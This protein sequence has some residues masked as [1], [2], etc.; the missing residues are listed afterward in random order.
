MEVGFRGE[1]SLSPVK[2]AANW[3]LHG[4][5]FATLYCVFMNAAP[6]A[7][8][9]PV[10]WAIAFLLALRLGGWQYF[11]GHYRRVVWACWR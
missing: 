11:W 7:F 2:K 1:T 6:R 8:G 10:M 9:V 4:L 5:I 3:Q